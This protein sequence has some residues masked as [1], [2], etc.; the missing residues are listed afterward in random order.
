MTTV[1][2]ALTGLAD[3][4][5]DDLVQFKADLVLRMKTHTQTIIVQDVESREEQMYSWCSTL[6]GL[7]KTWA[8]KQ[9]KK[10]APANISKCV[11]SLLKSVCE[12]NADLL[13][14]KTKFLQ[15]VEQQVSRRME[16]LK[17]CGTAGILF[18]SEQLG[19]KGDEI[20]AAANAINPHLVSMVIRL[21]QLCFDVAKED[22]TLPFL[23]SSRHQPKWE[24]ML[25]QQGRLLVAEEFSTGMGSVED[26]RKDKYPPLGAMK[27]WQEMLAAW[28]KEHIGGSEKRGRQLTKKLLGEAL[29]EVTFLASESDLAETPLTQKAL[30]R[31]MKVLG[32][33]VVWSHCLKSS[34]DFLTRVT[35]R[36]WEAFRQQGVIEKHMTMPT[37]EPE[38]F[39]WLCDRLL[40]AAGGGTGKGT[41]ARAAQGCQWPTYS[42]TLLGRALLTRFEAEFPSTMALGLNEHSFYQ[43]TAEAL[44]SFQSC[45]RGDYRA[46]RAACESIA[47]AVRTGSRAGTG[48]G[49]SGT[50]PWTRSR[51]Q[52]AEGLR[53]GPTGPG[54]AASGGASAGAGSGTRITRKRGLQVQDEPSAS[55]LAGTGSLRHGAPGPDP[56]HDGDSEAEVEPVARPT[57]RTRRQ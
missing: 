47:S 4:L 25:N 21:G 51:R 29:K 35:L 44:E 53:T 8:G 2:Q 34:G 28:V 13:E 3:S 36:D 1:H 55:S 31:F 54:T 23:F 12:S 22:G 9:F 38:Q 41:V 15:H 17:A 16:A 27:R 5:F 7:Y 24:W 45:F 26:K 50:R 43:Y 40:E 48:G 19:G 57:T 6:Q 52:V 14:V 56:R 42:R 30:E 10:K 11:D 33:K 37:V 49:E 32:V 46:A 39:L 18:I 20:G